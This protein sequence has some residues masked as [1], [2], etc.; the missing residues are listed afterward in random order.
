MAAVLKLG[1]FALVARSCDKRMCI[2]LIYFV[3][4]EQNAGLSI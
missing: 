4:D 2:T 1:T 3:L